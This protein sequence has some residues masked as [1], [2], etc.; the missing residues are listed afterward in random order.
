MRINIALGMTSSWFEYAQVTIA[1]VLYNA[2]NVDEYY[3]YIM[4]NSFEDF[5]KESFLRLSKIFPANFEFI[6]MDDS[7]FNGAIHDWLGVSSSYRLRLSSLVS[8]S[9]I[10][11]LDSDTMV[12][13]NIAPLYSTNL[14]NYYIAMAPDKCSEL[15]GV[16][17]DLSKE[18]VFY[19]AGVQLINLDKFRELNLEEVIM[20]KL[21]KNRFWTDQDVINDVC[22]SHILEL[23]LKFNI[24][25]SEDY[26]TCR[27][28]YDMTI[29]D[30]VIVHYTSKPWVSNIKMPFIEQWWDYHS[31]IS[32]L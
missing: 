30:P 22:K 11:Y 3:F 20:H 7:Y 14:S 26:K 2:E 28:Q 31:K 17:I 12:R 32:Q 16:R 4:A 15:M 27:F 24:M 29:E 1:S 10:L 6:L 9:K 8:E 23:P 18:D 25:P 21:R 13:K 5:Q 19:N